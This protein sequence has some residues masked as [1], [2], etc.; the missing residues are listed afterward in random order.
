MINVMF[1]CDYIKSNGLGGAMIWSLET[2]DFL[3]KCG[4]GNNPLL[5]AIRT[6]LNGEGPVII[7]ISFYFF[8]NK[9]I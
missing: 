6:S 9:Q 5:T 3:G 2:D 7:V 4:L 8:F 1:Q